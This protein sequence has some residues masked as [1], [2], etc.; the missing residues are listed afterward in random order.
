M[1]LQLRLYFEENSVCIKVE[2][3]TFFEMEFEKLWISAP[4]YVEDFI[5]TVCIEFCFI[6]GIFVDLAEISWFIATVI[7]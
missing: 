5:S 1:L 4:R 2:L 3:T 7:Y 6:F